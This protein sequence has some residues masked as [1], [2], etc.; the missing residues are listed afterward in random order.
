ME[1][2]DPLEGAPLAAVTSNCVRQLQGI[3]ELVVLARLNVRGLSLAA[4]NG[5]Q[6]ARGVL[7]QVDVDALHTKSG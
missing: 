3:R 1:N 5:M 2:G 6:L 7:V 4:A